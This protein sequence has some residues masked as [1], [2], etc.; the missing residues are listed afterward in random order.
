MKKSEVKIGGVYTA[1]VSG[2]VVPGTYSRVEG[3][4]LHR[5]EVR[6]LLDE[7]GGDYWQTLQR[8]IDGHLLAHGMIS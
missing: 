8:F 3:E 4:L 6:D 7:P 5:F 2:K 1:K